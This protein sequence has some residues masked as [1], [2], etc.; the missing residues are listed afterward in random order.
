MK[1]ITVER[2]EDNGKLSFNR[3]KDGRVT[4]AQDIDKLIVGCEQWSARCLSEHGAAQTD[5]FCH[6]KVGKQQHPMHDLLTFKIT[7]P[8]TSPA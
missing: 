2:R 8:S 6:Q 3:D 4:F 7:C 1:V 5:D